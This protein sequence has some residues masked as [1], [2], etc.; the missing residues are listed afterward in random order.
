MEHS[1]NFVSKSHV[2]SF[3]SSWQFLLDQLMNIFIQLEIL[4]LLILWCYLLLH[5]HP[6]RTIRTVI[7]AP[8]IRTVI[9]SPGAVNQA[10]FHHIRLLA[11]LLTVRITGAGI[12]VRIQNRF[13]RPG[14]PIGSYR[15][16]VLR[17]PSSSDA[18]TWKA[19]P[20]KWLFTKTCCRCRTTNEPSFDV[21]STNFHKTSSTVVCK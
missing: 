2:F 21:S 8:V 18:F 17:N 12:T 19:L 11:M 10:Y 5:T 9:T 20:I 7:P 14:C 4:S 1:I 15:N 3:S 13:V 16:S 6:D